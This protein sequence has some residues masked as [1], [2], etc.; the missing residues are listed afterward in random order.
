M[1]QSGCTGFVDD[2][3]NGLITHDGQKTLLRNSLGA[4]ASVEAPVGLRDGRQLHPPSG[5]RADEDF[6]F[7]IVGGAIGSSSLA[8]GSFQDAAKGHRVPL[9]HT[10][11][12]LQ[13][14]RSG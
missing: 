13:D 12:A 10:R 7:E 6:V 14:N 11:R 8:V 1:L 4:F 2:R 9:K 3:H 5:R